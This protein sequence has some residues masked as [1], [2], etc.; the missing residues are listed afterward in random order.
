MVEKMM[1]ERLLKWQAA[2]NALR[3]WWVQMID[4]M[5]MVMVL[6]RKYDVGGWV[7]RGRGRG[8]G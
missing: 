2:I 5:V 3:W 7:W 4:W 8:E 1:E 6:R